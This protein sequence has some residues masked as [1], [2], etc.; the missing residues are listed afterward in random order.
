MHHW[1]VTAVPRQPELIRR[2]PTPCLRFHKRQ[3]R[4]F[5][6]QKRVGQQAESVF[7]SES[8]LVRGRKLAFVLLVDI[9]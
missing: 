8:S 5:W 7:L 6:S 1:G 3:R 9:S 2:R 4:A